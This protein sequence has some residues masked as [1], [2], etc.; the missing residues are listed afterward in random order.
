MTRRIVLAAMGVLV[1]AAAGCQTLSFS[2]PTTVDP[3]IAVP[4]Q[5]QTGTAVN[6]IS[7]T[8]AAPASEAV[9][10]AK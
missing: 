3:K 5:L 8:P 10:A 4:P 7:T 1:A 6:P 9:A 2:T